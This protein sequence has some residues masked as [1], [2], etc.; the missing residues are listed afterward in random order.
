MTTV[1]ISISFTIEIEMS[2]TE[3]SISY[4]IEIDAVS[5]NG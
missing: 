4:P 5:K 3:T 2:T 1:E